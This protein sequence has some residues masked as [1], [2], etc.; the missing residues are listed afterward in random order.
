MT[1]GTP[2]KV[3]YTEKAQSEEHTQE[4][5]PETN[6]TPMEIKLKESEESDDGQLSEISDRSDQNI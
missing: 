4:K 2:I 6:D 5:E 1:F 3:G